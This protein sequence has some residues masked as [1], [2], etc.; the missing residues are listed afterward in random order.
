MSGVTAAWF[1]FRVALRNRWRA[2]SA[3][4]LLAG[5]VGG[6][7]M[8]AVAG[9]RRT[10]S[11]LQRVVVDTHAADVLVNPNNGALTDAQWR[12]MAQLP[13]VAESTKGL[14]APEV[15]VGANGRPDFGAL[16]SVHGNIVFE[17][18]DGYELHGIDRPAVI[19]GR[20]PATDEINALVVNEA[21]AKFNHLRV[22]SR[23]K[24]AFFDA[25]AAQSSND[26]AIPKLQDPTTLT[27]VGIIRPLDDA[28]R[29]ADDPRL[30]S[31]YFLTQS[32]SR[33]IAKLG[34]L[35][36]G[37]RVR[38]R[39]PAQLA[40]FEQQAR[41]IAGSD[42][43]DFQELS[44]TLQ[45]ARRAIHPYVFALWL[46]ALL[47]ALAGA[48]VVGQIAARQQRLE[49]GSRPLLRALGATR[50]D[51]GRVALLR[52]L[53]V[54]TVAALVS[55]VVAIAGSPIMPIGPLR[56]LEPDRGISVDVTVI[57]LGA[58]G[59]ALALTAQSVLVAIRR[60]ARSVARPSRLA[61]MFAGS[62]GS[63]PVVTGV[64]FALDPGRGDSA[65]P[66]RST[67]FGV[68][69]AVAALVATLVFAASLTH[70]T[71]TP[72][73]Y[74]WVW[75]YQIEPGGELS[76]A[77]L[78][79]AAAGLER[80]PHVRGAA[81]GAYS[82]LTIAAQTVGAIAVQTGHDVPVVE[83]LSGREPRSDHEVALGAQTLR[84]LHRRVGS[85][86][87]ITVGGVTRPFTVVGEAVFPR[88][89][90]YPASEPTGLGIGAAMTLDGLARFG[91]LDSSS[92]RSPLAAGP[93]VLVDATSGTKAALFERLAF[94]GN[95]NAGLVLSA[96]RPNYVVSYQHLERTPLALT[97][98]LVLLA[99][100]TTVHLLVSMVR[101]RRRDLGMLRALGFTSAQMR[102][103]V[104][105]LATTIIGLTLV[106]AI[107]VGVIAGR[108]LWSLTSH[109]LGIPVHG[110]VPLAAIAAV[111]VA[112]LAV[113]NAVALVPAVRAARMDPAQVLRSE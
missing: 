51:L 80:D 56:A 86:L 26:A 23:L 7:V 40:A 42:V 6:V 95:P 21:A 37:L 102:A 110:V 25:P 104:L 112:T 89:A 16:E 12:A 111:G 67:A 5:V 45:R 11:S 2:W 108:A 88:F 31:M 91:P 93:F 47:A 66:V 57:L 109:W 64:R 98:L 33:R 94:H 19:A 52:G 87:D 30:S 76:T 41:R 68:G 27:V 62:S 20:I 78:E 79:H 92:A 14:A 44:G 36:G 55:I 63:P 96:Q 72:R 113:G 71:S 74:G 43:L 4:G 90:P 84:S 58:L 10:D 97:A 39:D 24:V 77:T 65:I 75:S 17:N 83:V 22:G 73:M 99:V 46:F 15:P 105:V 101:R 13:Q 70:F 9:A 106:V 81:V 35:Y 100:A 18:P 48:A 8:V 28:T 103:A 53:V 1:Q 34:Y 32:L 82:Q 38:L 60:P 61:D 54:G 3:I 107:P 59:L 69:L 49:A 85:S 29:A 50:G